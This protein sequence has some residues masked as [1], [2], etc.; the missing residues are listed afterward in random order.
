VREIVAYLTVLVAAGTPWLEVLLVVPAGILAGLAPA[1]VAVVAFVGNAVTLAPVVLAGDRVRTWWRARRA[2]NVAAGGV[3]EAADLAREDPGSHDLGGDQTPARGG[4][5]RARRVFDRYGLPGLA[6]LG[7]LVTGI[8]VAAVVAL[9]AGAPR[10]PT[11][12]WLTIGIAVWS[13]IAA[14]LTVVGVEA[15]VDR[16]TLPAVLR[17]SA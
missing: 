6:V 8:H 16:D 5:A 15:L 11:L 13:A 9:A 17:V 7:P 2:A 12:V 4:R 3:A 10:R 1:P 14:V